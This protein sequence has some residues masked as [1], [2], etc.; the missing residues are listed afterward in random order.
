MAC[1][2]PDYKAA[3]KQADEAF[4]D[5]MKLLKEKYHVSS[6]ETCEKLWGIRRHVR[7]HDQVKLWM[8]ECV[9]KLFEIDATDA[10]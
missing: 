2:G 1:Q 5:I 7:E 10:F 6:P 4:E 8:K 9:E 3:K